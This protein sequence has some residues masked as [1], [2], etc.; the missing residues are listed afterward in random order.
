MVKLFQEKL[1]YIYLGNWEEREGNSNIEVA[2]LRKH[3]KRKYSDNLIDKALL[4]LTNAVNDVGQQPYDVNRNVYTLLRYGVTVQ[5]DV[6]QHK[7]TVWLINWD[8]PQNNYFAIAEEVTIEGEHKKRPDIVIYVNG[9]ALGVIELKRS[10]VGIA[11]G[12]DRIRG[13]KLLNEG[14]DPNIIDVEKLE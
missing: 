3:L 10:T 6:G 7:E 5:P 13:R 14:G 8:E 1:F 4:I 12:I 9:I 11:E 2:L